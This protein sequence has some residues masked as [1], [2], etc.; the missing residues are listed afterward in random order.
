MNKIRIKRNIFLL[1][2]VLIIILLILKFIKFPYSTLIRNN[3]NNNKIREINNFKQNKYNNIDAVLLM[4]PNHGNLGD[5]AISIAEIKF[6]KEIV[7]NIKFVYNLKNHIN[8]I[9]NN[10][11]II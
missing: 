6:L 8:Y 5:Q 7:P 10:T 1:K 9:N 3:L 2:S 4:L 11:I